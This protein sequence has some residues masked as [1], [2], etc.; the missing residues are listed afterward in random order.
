MFKN[1]TFKEN[2]AT[3]G[4]AVTVASGAWVSFEDCTFTSNQAKKTGS[5]N[6]SWGNDVRLGGA[7]SEVHISG[8][9]IVEIFARNKS[10]V[11][12]D[13]NLTEGSNVVLNWSLD[14]LNGVEL[15]RIPTTGVQFAS[16]D[17]GN[18][19]QQYINLG[20]NMSDYDLVYSGNIGNLEL[21]D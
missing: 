3:E 10:T 4:G 15:G 8:K 9:M 5:G 2:E 14:P 21:K 19:S 13:G 7:A 12:V 18:A 16:E 11:H 6:A 1:C 17:I 20:V